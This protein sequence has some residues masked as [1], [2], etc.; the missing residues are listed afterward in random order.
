MS[1]SDENLKDAHLAKA[2]RHAPDSDVAPSEFTR[3]IVLD[4][5]NKS[6]KT[7]LEARQKSWFARLIN[8]FNSWQI[9]RWQLTGLG[10]LAA[11]LLV[12]VMIWHENPDDPMQVGTAPDAAQNEATFSTAPK[13]EPT[14]AQNELARN[15]LEKDEASAQS[16][17]A[18]EAA[19]AEMAATGAPVSKHAPDNSQ[20]KTETKIAESAEPIEQK[21]K[22]APQVAAIEQ[23][24]ATEQS[25]DKPVVT[26]APEAVVADAE[27]QLSQRA[28]TREQNDAVAMPAPVPSAPVVVDAAPASVAAAPV[29]M[30]KK[31]EATAQS[32]ASTKQDSSSASGNIETEEKRQ[33]ATKR[34]GDDPLADAIVKTGGTVMAKQDIQAGKLRLL[35]VADY[36]KGK[37]SD[38]NEP[39]IAGFEDRVDAKTAYNIEVIYVCVAT[40]QLIKEV[41]LYN[42]TMRTWHMEKK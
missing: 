31:A 4:Y 39:F 30:K 12:V 29:P 37:P 9:P 3:K 21:A 36:Y 26:S 16:A 5:A 10:S 32:E 28:K 41:A 22:T 42:Q 1:L 35:D 15:Q 27:K 25:A 24:A 18:P 11:S 20:N 19:S 2:L 6:V 14:L 23:S 17:A 8:A 7:K 40:Q 34:I 33:K 38:C 13:P